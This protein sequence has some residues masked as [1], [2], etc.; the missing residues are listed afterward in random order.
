MRDI[1]L[2]KKQLKADN[3]SIVI[4]KKHL[5]IYSSNTRGIF[6]IY[7]AVMNKNIDTKGA[8]VAD[9]VIGKGAALLCAY[10]KIISVHAG[11]ISQSALKVLIDNDIE[12]SYDK[13][14]QQI[15][16]RARDGK[17]PVETLSD[18]IENPEDVLKPIYDFLVKVGMI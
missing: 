4:V 8:S 5:I 6:P 1:E 14:V 17:C 15:A 18:N 12:V 2:A 3:Q 11:L 9:K 16:N 13:I 10:G 7:D